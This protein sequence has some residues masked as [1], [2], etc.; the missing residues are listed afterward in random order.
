MQEEYKNEKHSD[1]MKMIESTHSNI[2]FKIKPEV[3]ID[4]RVAKS[5]P[6]ITEDIGCRQETEK[7]NTSGVNERCERDLK[8]EK[9]K[10]YFE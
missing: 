10:T 7:L 9:R 8:F 3:N 4:N 2:I 1:D 6:M 5:M